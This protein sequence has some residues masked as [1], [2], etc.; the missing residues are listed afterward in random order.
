MSL[1]ELLLQNTHIYLDDSR[2]DMDAAG[3]MPSLNLSISS[4]KDSDFFDDV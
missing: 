2:R 4:L 3:T 1:C